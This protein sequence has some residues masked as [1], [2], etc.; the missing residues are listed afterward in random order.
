LGSA[1]AVSAV[2]PYSL[3]SSADDIIQPA[4]SWLLSQRNPTDL[5]TNGAS[6]PAS[7]SAGS[8]SSAD[9][10]MMQPRGWRGTEL[11]RALLALLRLAEGA[12]MGMEQNKAMNDADSIIQKM[13][14]QWN[15]NDWIQSRQGLDIQ[16][17]LFLLKYLIISIRFY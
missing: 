13:I 17:L 16:L 1:G 3:P 6:A 10:W 4:V 9:G 2:N 5:D 11:P 15:S 14:R 12:R 7:T 8:S